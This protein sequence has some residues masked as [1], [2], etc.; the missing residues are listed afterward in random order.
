MPNVSPSSKLLNKWGIN[1]P[2][3]TK[4]LS[5]E[6]QN[7]QDKIA[8]ETQSK[9]PIWKQYASQGIDALANIPKGYLGIEPAEDESTGGYL[10]N[11]LFQSNETSD[12]YLAELQSKTNLP[13]VPLGAVSMFPNKA[14]REAGTST[15]RQLA[16]KLPSPKLQTALGEFADKYPRI[17]AH[18]S[19]QEGKLFFP[20]ASAAVEI[21][22]TNEKIATPLITKFTKSGIEKSDLNLDA[23]RN[24]VFHEGTHAAQVLGNKDLGKLYQ[25]SSI[26]SGYG[27]NPFEINA[28]TSGMRNYPGGPKRKVIN[29]NEQLQN[30]AEN[31]LNDTRLNRSIDTKNNAQTILDILKRRGM[32]QSTYDTE[33]ENQLRNFHNLSEFS[34]IK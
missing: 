3:K 1:L 4:P 13:G 16:S 23:A 31:R 25:N 2:P 34:I 21:P 10:A 22:M 32:L 33:F 8:R 14:L 18:M 12:P 17:A 27:R 5:I 6:E 11:K 7:K 24:M 20:T 26:L 30:A 15:F 9:N 29:I 19:P 28:N